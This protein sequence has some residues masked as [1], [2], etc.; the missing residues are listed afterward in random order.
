MENEETSMIPFEKCAVCGADLAEKKVEKL[1][2]GGNHVAALSALALVCTGCGER[3]YAE[4]TVRRFEEVRARLARN[5][6]A[7]LKRIGEAFAA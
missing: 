7:D 2:R 5:D 6:T 1:V 4:E 3:Y